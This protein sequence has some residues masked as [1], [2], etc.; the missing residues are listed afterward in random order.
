MK[1][2]Q[3]KNLNFGFSERKIIKNF[4]FSLDDGEKIF[5][6]GFVG[7]G[8]TTLFKIL[9]GLIPVFYKG[10][11]EG[12]IIVFG[13]KNPVKFRNHI[14]M[15]SQIPE[16]Q[17]VFEDVLDEVISVSQDQS[18]ESIFD[19][20]KKINASDLLERKTSQL[21]DGERQLVVILAALSSQKKCLILDEPFSHLYPSRVN[22]LLDL[23]L[24]SEQSVIFTDK[25]YEHFEE[26]FD[27]TF[28][29]PSFNSPSNSEVGD[30]VRF[31][32]IQTSVEPTEE[33]LVAENIYFSY[34]ESEMEL[35]RGVDITVRRGELVSIIG[36]NGSGKTTLLKILCGILKPH[37]GRIHCQERKIS[38][39]LQYPNYCFTS[40]S[41][42]E[43]VSTS[44]KLVDLFGLK[45]R[46]DRHPHTLSAGEAKLVSL[47]K[48]F[49]GDL[50][51]LDEPTVYLDPN[52][53]FKLVECLKREGKT[54]IITT[55]D[56][57]LADLCDTTYELKN[58]RLKEKSRC[59]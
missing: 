13:E 12:D 32:N 36:D 9:T 2:I 37:C 56:L 3:L 6:K 8:K 24:D 23:F 31:I 42:K 5:V 34:P 58:G 15:V 20:A 53:R 22:K 44:P 59:G 47:L 41:V 21:S 48:A 43:E 27:N 50:L 26:R 16:E 28:D 35:L 38:I 55:H 4:D 40:R 46:L 49:S 51:L 1:A 25:R 14:H 33:I 19:N 52:F 57:E 11:L 29:F 30:K 54:A 17:I 7:S 18:V 39:S 45:G 10:H